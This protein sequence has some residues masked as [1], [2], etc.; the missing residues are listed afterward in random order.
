MAEVLNCGQLSIGII[1]G[2]CV[3]PIVGGIKPN[4]VLVNHSDIDL[5]QTEIIDGI[6][7]KLV[8]K[9]SKTGYL[10]QMLPRTS[11]TT[12]ALAKG[13]YANGW[14]QNLTLRILNLGPDVK[15]FVEDLSKAKVVAIVENNYVNFNA[16]TGKGNTVYE[17]YGFYT[18]LEL[19]E[20]T[21]DSEDA[22]TKGGYVV[23]LGC[24]ENTKEPTL[25]ISVFDT[26]LETTKAMIDS[27]VE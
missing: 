22:D 21:R 4:V 27:L 17:A 2:N 5:A 19:N 25:P 14:D 10:A 15:K 8:L 1:G 24:G 20:G 11:T 7:T 12:I 6:I 23:T 9:A 18:G 3:D 13:A 26:D 16:A